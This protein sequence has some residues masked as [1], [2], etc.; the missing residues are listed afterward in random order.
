MRLEF[1]IALRYLRSSK[2]SRSVSFITNI[3]V[4]GVTIG[5][6]AL[7]VVLSIMNGFEQDLKKALVGA[8]AH[9]VVS[10]FTSGGEQKI[11]NSP[12]LIAKIRK[13]IEAEHISLNKK[14]LTFGQIPRRRKFIVVG[15]F[16]SGL[17]AYDEIF[18]LIDLKE[19]QKTFRLENKL[20]LL[21]ANRY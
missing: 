1:F 13:L 21:F 2:K 14:Y 5:V 17:S 10:A 8:N 11:E 12:K 7:I 20:G 3:A 18:T 6:A 9:L 4:V 15:F 16:E 19:A